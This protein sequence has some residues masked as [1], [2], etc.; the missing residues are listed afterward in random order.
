MR[1]AWAYT[2]A[3]VSS[4]L[5]PALA[6]GTNTLLTRGGG[7]YYEDDCAEVSATLVVPFL[8]QSQPI[9]PVKACLC[10]S[11]IPEFISTSPLAATAVGLAGEAAVIAALT[12]M[13]EAS[14]GK[15]ECSYPPHSVASCE[16]SNPC[17]F[18]CTNGYTAYPSDVPTQ[19][20]C[21]PPYTE[22]NGNCGVYSACPSGVY[23][24]RDTVR[25]AGER[26]FGG[27]TACGIPGRGHNTWE[28]IDTQTELESCGGCPYPELSS[29]W[30]RGADCTVIPGI[31]DVSCIR[32]QCVVH[33]CMPGYDIDANNSECMYSEDKDPAVLAAQYGL[34]HTPL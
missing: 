32:G 14:A 30:K 1:T 13:I 34:E 27:L 5:S 2:A 3:I 18:S 21:E 8:G 24:K 22:C 25:G 7:G 16:S 17:Y 11:A 12:A 19:C 6:R 31:A 9:G 20:V 33:K 23:G 10:V 26:C 28:C 29:S 4:L 15:Q